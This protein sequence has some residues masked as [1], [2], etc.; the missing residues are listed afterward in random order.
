MTAGAEAR[1]RQ[2]LDAAVAAYDR[3]APITPRGSFPD[4]GC[5]CGTH[6][7][8]PAAQRR[9]RIAETLAA[10]AAADTA[11]TAASGPRPAV[12]VERGPSAAN[13]AGPGGTTERP[14][15]VVT[16]GV[17]VDTGH[18]HGDPI[19]V[20]NLELPLELLDRLPAPVT[21]PALI[22][23]LHRNYAWDRWL[24]TVKE[25]VETIAAPCATC[26]GTTLCPACVG[27]SPGAYFCAPCGSSGRCPA[28]GPALPGLGSCSAAPVSAATAALQLVPDQAPHPE[29]PGA[30]PGAPPKPTPLYPE[31]TSLPDV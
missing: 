24:T 12:V 16:V 10:A 4:V 9:H 7:P 3:H 22:A 11:V 5:G 23:Q 17:F 18:D 25:A 31:V 1:A 27:G 30:K 19:G 20:A 8:G 15:L 26:R 21:E 2:A 6:W 14:R 28:C 29:T 13:P